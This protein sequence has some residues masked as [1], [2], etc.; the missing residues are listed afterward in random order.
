VK[1]L[2]RPRL[3]LYLIVIGYFV[4]SGSVQAAE[5][6]LSLDDYWQKV[7]QTRALLNSLEDNSPETRH[8]QLLAVADEWERIT[9]VKLP[10]GVLV[11]VDHTFLVTHLRADSPD[12]ARLNELLT[13]LLTARHTWPQA[14]H[15]SSDLEALESVLARP[16]FQW[17]PEQPSLL[18]ELWRRFWEFFWRQIAPLLPD[19]GLITLDLDVLRYV[20]IGLSSVLL[21]LVILFIL[22]ELL[23][24]L[25]TE[26][27]VAP[28]SQ[29]GDEI[30]TADTAFKRAQTLSSAGD[31]RTAVRYL[32]LS[33]LLVL[34]E[35]GL[36]RYDRAQTNREYLRSV[37]HL[38][39]LATILRE[40]IEVFDRVWYGYQSLDETTYAQ[41]AA[42]VTKLR[43]QK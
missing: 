13:T 26:A 23:V 12:L 33:S 25:V 8:E 9:Q 40:V 22:R 34:D 29:S 41:Y 6:P 14:K 28:D 24:D 17:R 2:L 18:A 16:E 32:Y 10:D 19:N 15:T 42:Q 31:Y 4:L 3:I 11:S 38:P 1:L 20:L 37:A 39:S 21:L 5:P 36:L 7:E 35:R 27:K 43:Q 30:L